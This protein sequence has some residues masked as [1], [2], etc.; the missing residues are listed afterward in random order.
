[1]EVTWESEYLHVN[2]QSLK[3]H[4]SQTSDLLALEN[5]AQPLLSESLIWKVLHPMRSEKQG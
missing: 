4:S 3:A 2:E 1:M 5:H